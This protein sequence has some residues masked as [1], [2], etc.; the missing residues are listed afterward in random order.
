MSS[1]RILSC[2][3]HLAFLTVVLILAAGSMA[4]RGVLNE[5]MAVASDDENLFRDA[6]E[7]FI[8]AEE[9]F[10]D[11]GKASSTESGAGDSGETSDDADSSAA[12]DG[13][14]GRK[15]DARKRIKVQEG[16]V[17][18]PRKEFDSQK[19][20]RKKRNKTQVKK[21][22]K[23]A[24]QRAKDGLKAI[25]DHTQKG[26]INARENQSDAVEAIDSLGGNERP[27]WDEGYSIP[28]EP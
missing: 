4:E 10:I 7:V 19:N 6:E 13:K 22:D 5:H 15:L 26:L 16:R 28:I 21:E 9:V 12:N 14:D 8:D 11:D 17:T 20:A 23:S 1:M 25:Q 2:V 27:D 3:F 18:D 24:E